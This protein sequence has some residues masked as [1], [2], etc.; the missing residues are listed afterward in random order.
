MY[1]CHAVDACHAMDAC[2]HVELPVRDECM[3]CMHA[4][5]CAHQLYF[6]LPVRDECMPEQKGRDHRDAGNLEGLEGVGRDIEVEKLQT[7]LG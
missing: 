1:A 6:E 7:I 3:P 5:P 4:M 2:A